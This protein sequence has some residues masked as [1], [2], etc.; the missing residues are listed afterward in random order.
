M[1]LKDVIF[2]GQA[3]QMNELEKMVALGR[4]VVVPHQLG[5]L[6]IWQAGHVT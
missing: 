5:A 2:S 3:V 1:P 4:E 6:V